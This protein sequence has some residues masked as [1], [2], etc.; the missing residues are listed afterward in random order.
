MINPR[1]TVTPDRLG[2][3]LKN[4]DGEHYAV[5]PSCK[6]RDA[7]PRSHP[8][9]RRTIL[10]RVHRRKTCFSAEPPDRG[11]TLAPQSP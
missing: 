5:M 10:D 7:E 8:A 9:S 6:P 1:S 2:A 4:A 3:L 11:P